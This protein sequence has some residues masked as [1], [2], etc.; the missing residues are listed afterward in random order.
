MQNTKKYLGARMQELRRQKKL[1]QAQLAE[2]L[3]I[4]PK[5]ISK[6]ECGRCFPSFELLDRIADALEIEPYEL[7]QNSHLKNKDELLDEINELLKNTSIEK[8]RSFYMIL[9]NFY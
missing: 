4:A 8:I 3:N 1:K 5:H 9:K 6:I 7:L 2:L